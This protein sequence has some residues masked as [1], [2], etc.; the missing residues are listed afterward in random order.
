MAQFPDAKQAIDNGFVGIET[1]ERFRQSSGVGDFKAKQPELYERLVKAI[2]Y[3]KLAHQELETVKAA[4][5][6]LPI[7]VT[8][9]D[10][11]D[12]SERDARDRLKQSA[13]AATLAQLE[14]V[15]SAAPNK[16]AK[17]SKAS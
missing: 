8:L 10:L 3:V 7:G 12:V 14:Q 17:A 9:G 2:V 11:L 15:G 13:E 16:P 4:A 1:A 6:S 5:S